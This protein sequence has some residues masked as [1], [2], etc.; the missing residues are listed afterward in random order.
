M[1]NETGSVKYENILCTVCL[2]HSKLHLRISDSL[3]YRKCANNHIFAH[4][5]GLKNYEP[6]ADQK[7]KRFG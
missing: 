2:K 6:K 1:S 3:S 7:D 4:K 5:E